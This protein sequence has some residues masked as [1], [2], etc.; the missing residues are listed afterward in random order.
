MAV[1][2]SSRPGGD[3]VTNGHVCYVLDSV[4]IWSDCRQEPQHRINVQPSDGAVGAPTGRRPKIMMIE[5][6]Q[7]LVAM[8][9][10]YLT[11]AGFQVATAAAASSALTCLAQQAFDLVV[12]DL[13]LPDGDGLDL[14]RT[15]RQG[16]TMLPVIVVTGRGEEA[17]RVVG[18]ELGA[19]DYLVKPFFVRE[20]VARIRA[21]LR[22]IGNDAAAAA[23]IHLGGLV[24]DTDAHVIRAAGEPIELTPREYTL[25]E[26]L[27]TTPG[28]VYSREQLLANVWESSAEWQAQA[29]VDEHVY[30]IR[31]KLTSA[32]VRSP[33][34]TTVRGFG[35]RLDP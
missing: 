14:L 2:V 10:A 35:Y 3:R 17:D 9:D 33:K 20:L 23:V 22:R 32:D 21:V 29:T 12:L 11:R 19:D 8:C 31:R 30:R 26:F 7:D 4:R 15:L 5:D 6:D 25:L 1:G 34:I 24:I 28:R 16:D 13:G 27:A 18:L